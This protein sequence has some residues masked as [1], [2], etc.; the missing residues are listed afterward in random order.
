MD[1]WNY[2][3]GWEG[4][5]IVYS[6]DNSGKIKGASCSVAMMCANQYEPVDICAAKNE[7]EGAILLTYFNDDDKSEAIK[8]WTVSMHIKF[9]NWDSPFLF[10]TFSFMTYDAY[11]W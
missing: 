7:N 1:E 9:R 10:Y 3:K 8:K 5:A 4:D 2:V 6:H 11:G